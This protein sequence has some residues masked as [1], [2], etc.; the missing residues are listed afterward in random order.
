MLFDHGSLP[1]QAKDARQNVQITMYQ[2]EIGLVSRWHQV[3]T[4]S[5]AQK[6]SYRR[7]NLLL[8]AVCRVAVNASLFLL[9]PGA[10]EMEICGELVRVAQ[11]VL[12]LCWKIVSA[13]IPRRRV[14]AKSWSG[15]R[16]SLLLLF[17]VV[18]MHSHDLEYLPFWQYIREKPINGAVQVFSS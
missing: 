4:Q 15:V 17:F 16:T 3:N 2:R 7:W 18:R 5:L 8:L 1:Y 10:A 6:R 11:L 14:G 12:G 9:N 13:R